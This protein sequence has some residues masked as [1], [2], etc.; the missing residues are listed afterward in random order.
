MKNE[1]SFETQAESSGSAST[2]PGIKKSFQ[3]AGQKLK[4]KVQEA[5]AQ[6][7]EQGEKYLEH[8]KS[9]TADCVGKIGD[10]LRES[11]DRFE[12]EEDPNIAHYARLL[13][14]KVETAAS[15]VRE[16]DFKELQSDAMDFTRRHP[17]MVY[18]GMF[19]AGLL[20]ARFLKAS[21]ANRADRSPES[22]AGEN[23]PSS[24]MVG[25]V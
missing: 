23:Y 8:N 5:T 14:D 1:P 3:E 11:A 4:S 9:R 6:A 13:A 2:A 21:G 7:K 16:R 20:L 17:A 12:A 19:T 18:G 24:E 10:S 25:Q 22:D 15:Y